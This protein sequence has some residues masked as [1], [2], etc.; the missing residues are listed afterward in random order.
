MFESLFSP[1][2]MLPI[3]ASFLVLTA[4]GLAVH[5]KH[6][7]TQIS[8]HATAFGT[9]FS[10]DVKIGNATFDLL[11]DTGSADTW[12]IDHDYLCLDDDWNELTYKDCNYGKPYYQ[13][14][15]YEAIDNETFAVQYGSGNAYGT[16]AYEDIALGNITV[17]RQKF[18]NVN[19][20]TDSADG[21]RSGIMGFGY[22][23]LTSAH[24]AGFNFTNTSLLVDRLPYNPWFQNAVEQHNVEPYFSVALERTSLKQS[25]GPGGYVGLG[26]IV[27]VPHTGYFVS[28]PAEVNKAIP[29]TLTGGKPTLTLWTLTV[30][31]T[32]CDG[33]VNSTAFQAVPDT[34]TWLNVYP[35]KRAAAINAAFDPPATLLQSSDDELLYSVDCSAKPP[36]HGVTIGNTT[37]YHNPADMIF[38]NGTGCMSSISGFNPQGGTEVYFLG[39]AFFKNVVAVFDFGRS[40]MRFSA[41]V[42]ANSS[43]VPVS[44][45]STRTKQF[46]TVVSVVLV[47]MICWVFSSTV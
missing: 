43:S 6:T 22:P 2:R 29:K 40:E 12:V 35:A 15:S 13:S 1:S 26:V 34:G 24:P 19:M 31:G 5:A 20:T 41:R 25:A 38:W 30:D 36:K 45:K 39:D 42:S 9:L 17:D 18:G 23:I 37:F 21:I 16:L 28:A 10:V 33:A 46:P 4:P 8:L 47:G 3:V 7:G 44:S 14:S 32:T 27:D 11:F